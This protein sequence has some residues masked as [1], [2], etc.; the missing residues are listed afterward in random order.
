MR[1]YE[2]ALA[3]RPGADRQRQ[4]AARPTPHHRADQRPPRPAPGRSGQHGARQRHRRPGRDHADAA[5]RRRLHRSRRTTCR[6]CCAQAARGRAARRSRPTTATAARQLA[7]GT[8]LT[9]DNPIDPDHRHACASRPSSRTTTTRSSRTSSSTRASLLDV[10]RGATLVPDGRRPARHAGHVRL[11]RE[12]RPDRR[13][14][15]G[16]RS[17]VTE[18]DDT[19][20]RRRR[21]RRASW[22]WSTAPTALRA[23][24]AGRRCRHAGRAATEQAAVMNLSR[25]FILRP[26]ATTLL[27]VAI[28][29]AGA[30]GLPPA[31]GLGAAA[32]RLP[33][34]PG[35]HL[36]SR[37][38][39]RT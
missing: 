18:G 21:R 37:A 11:R 19:V 16:A 38:P 1:Q 23:G 10:R 4:A 36:L 30:L 13:G 31:A 9:I 33:D 32:G 2:A 25:P 6:R 39:A 8:L 24:R 29:L 12:A 17:G 15:A 22:W 26:V 27:M 34:H 3:D 5:D 28:L 7:T 14:A 20:D 35:R